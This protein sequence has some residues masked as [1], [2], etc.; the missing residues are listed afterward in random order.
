MTCATECSSNKDLRY[1]E[2]LYF[3][4]V[5][6][7]TVGFGDISPATTSGKVSYEL[8]LGA[9]PEISLLNGKIC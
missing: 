8:L 4:I 1:H 5:T 2:W 7:G 6:S 3:L 9:Y